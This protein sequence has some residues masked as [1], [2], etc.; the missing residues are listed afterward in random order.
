MLGDAEGA[1]RAVGSVEVDGDRVAAA[2][3][4][5]VDHGVLRLDVHVGAD[6]SGHVVADI[7]GGAGPDGRGQPAVPD[8]SK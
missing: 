1:H 5:A 2:V 6:V 3:E 7:L 4:P 8:E